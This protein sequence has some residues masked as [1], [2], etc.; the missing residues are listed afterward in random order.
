M[1][2]LI[3]LEGKHIHIV[4]NEEELQNFLNNKKIELEKRGCENVNKWLED[5]LNNGFTHHFTYY[6]EFV[7]PL[8]EIDIKNFLKTIDK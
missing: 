1:K 3:S 7:L 5:M 4:N 6:P 8:D 2:Y